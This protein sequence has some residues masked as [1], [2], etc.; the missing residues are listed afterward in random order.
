M[1]SFA[2]CFFL[3]ASGLI[4][5]TAPSFATMVGTLTLG[6]DDSVTFS[7]SGVTMIMND[8][9]ST[10][11]SISPLTVANTGADPQVTPA[12]SDSDKVMWSDYG[13]ILDNGRTV[14]DISA[15][16]TASL[17]G[18]TPEQLKDLIGDFDVPDNFMTDPPSATPE[19]RTLS[20]LM[21]GLLSV[22]I[23]VAKR[24][25]KHA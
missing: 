9:S 13:P 20:L 18:A 24:P 4:L 2:R 1:K 16:F 7:P 10:N 12:S 3:A 8:T 21:F 14:G 5:L 6:E 25:K 11:D 17:F 22:A 19:P 23:V 15:L